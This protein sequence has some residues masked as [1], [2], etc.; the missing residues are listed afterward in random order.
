DSAYEVSSISERAASFKGIY[1]DCFLDAFQH[2]YLTMVLDVDGRPVVPN[3]RLK[4]YLALEVPKRA[5]AHGATLSQR[6]DAEVC[7]DEPTYIAHVSGSDRSSGS[8][9]STSLTSQGDLPETIRLALGLA[10]DGREVCATV[11]DPEERA[12]CP[13]ELAA[14][15]KEVTRALAA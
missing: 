3:R 7:S 2:P 5:Q 1:T 10:G 4:T 9:G 11:G 6:P 13:D 12:A 14:L 8:D 15:A